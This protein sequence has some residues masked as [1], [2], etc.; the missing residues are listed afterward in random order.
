MIHE[1]ATLIQKKKPEIDAW[2]EK[3]YMEVEIPIYA[4][5]DIRDNGIKASIVDTNVFPAGFNNIAPDAWDSAAEAFKQFLFK[6]TVKRNILIVAEAHTR[7]LFYFSNLYAL[8]QI[9]ERA[10]YH[11]TLG[12]L[13]P[14]IEDR[15]EVFDNEG[16]ELVLERIRSDEGYLRTRSFE[17]G[18]VILN[19]DFSVADPLV[20]DGL[21][22]SVFPP[23]KLGWFERTKFNHFSH[24]ADL[25][26][27]FAEEVGIDP[28][29][30]NPLASKVDSVDFSTGENIEELSRAV[31]SLIERVAEKYK[32][33]GI[34][35]EPYVF[36]K[37]NSGTYGMG[38]MSVKS[39]KEIL[40]TNNRTRNNMTRGKQK[41]VIDSVIIQEGIPTRYSNKECTQEPVLYTV[42][43]N[44]VGGFMRTHDKK[45][46]RSSLNSPGAR[47]EPLQDH[48]YH[49]HYEL[50]A[51]LA[52][53]AVGREIE[54]IK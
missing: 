4:S 38:V 21:K 52:T 1:L 6:N 14:D 40:Q 24:F 42:A 51:H 20:M 50:L 26:T 28:W 30:L 2:L 19:N 36:V 46:E 48:H 23:V 27:E 18:A 9:V 49:S 12:T 47:F 33:Y 29:L 11:V 53:I 7:N 44:I 25:V 17:D 32:E 8:S 34:E 41:S 16:N 54:E 31:D 35:E 39:G 22:N 13:S 10:G 45:D 43:R 3:K 15:L 5:V 37:D